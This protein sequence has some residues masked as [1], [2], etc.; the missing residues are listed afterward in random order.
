MI[1]QSTAGFKV[2]H[3][4]ARLTEGG[5]ATIALGLHLGLPQFNVSSEYV[6]AFG[7]QA[8]K[9]PAE[10]TIGHAWRLGRR[11]IVIA[12]HSLQ[13]LYGRD[14]LPPAPGPSRRLKT[15]ISNCD[16]VHLHVVHSHIAPFQWLA[17]LLIA[18][19]KPVVWTLH[20]RWLLTGRCAITEGCQLWRKG[21]GACPTLRNYP[22]ARLDLSFK[23]YQQRRATA[24]QLLPQ[25]TLVCPSNDLANDVRQAYE[26]VRVEVIQNGL[27]KGFE[28]AVA[29]RTVIDMSKFCSPVNILFTADD[30]SDA[31]KTDPEIVRHLATLPDTTIHTVGRRSPFMG[32]NVVNHGY[33]SDRQA[34]VNLISSMDALIFTSSIDIFPLTVVE[35]LACGT[36]VLAVP[37]SASKE[38]LGGIFARPANDVEELVDMVRTHDFSR[39]TSNLNRAEL[40]VIGMEHFSHRRMINRYKVVYQDTLARVRS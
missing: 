2:L 4:N 26:D 34:M 33:V 36:P 15:S 9:N 39:T 29:A 17:D 8:G 38:V 19:G 22:P 24:H 37:S 16:I 40:S 1:D 20:D 13:S 28:S 5:A 3:I 25:T 7:H 10:S 27:D 18:S 32:G 23:T 6:Y 21:C 12:N 11:P 35:S 30:L 31:T 14:V